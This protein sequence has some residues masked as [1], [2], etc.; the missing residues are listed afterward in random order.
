MITRFIPR[1]LKDWLRERAAPL[2][3]DLMKYFP[4]QGSS[5]AYFIP[6]VPVLPQGFCSQ[7]LPIPPSSFFINYKTSEEYL[8]CGQRDVGAMLDALN[9]TGRSLQAGER[10]LDFGCS[11]G[12]MIRWL[13]SYSTNCEIWGADISAGHILW[14]KQYLTPHFNFLVSTTLPH[15][16]FEDRYFDL[17]YCG[18][19]FTHIEDLADAW[20]LELRR[21]LKPAGRL[22]LT[23]HDENTI[24]LLD[25]ERHHAL[26][27]NMTA[28]EKYNEYIQADYGAFSIYRGPNSQVFYNMDY[29]CRMV[30]HI[31]NV[32]SVTPEAY[33]Y[34]TAVLLERK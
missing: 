21:L 10:V 34:Q 29:F 19:V 13:K 9:K 7:G 14:C 20:L 32:V 1:R 12:R 30:S 17:I 16:P 27:G 11:G 2:P 22:Y 24:R 4:Y 5:A 31:F 18:S 6:R 28:N 23:I 25:Q 15:L 8:A 3:I 33:G 26:A